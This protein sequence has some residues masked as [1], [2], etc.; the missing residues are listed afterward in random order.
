M[1]ER[2]EEGEKRKKTGIGEEEY[3]RPREEE[4]KETK[5][6][7][8]REERE[9]VPAAR[10]APAP[11]PPPPAPP[12]PPSPR[13]FLPPRASPIAG[14]TQDCGRGGGGGFTP[15]PVHT[16]P[17]IFDSWTLLLSGFRSVAAAA[18]P[19]R[20]PCR[21]AATSGSPVFSTDAPRE[22]STTSTVKEK[23]PVGSWT[24][25]AVTWVLDTDIEYGYNKQQ[26]QSQTQAVRGSLVRASSLQ[27]YLVPRDHGPLTKE[28]LPRDGSVRGWR[29]ARPVCVRLGVL[30]NKRLYTAT[31]HIGDGDGF[32]DRPQR[33]RQC[34]K[35]SPHSPPSLSRLPFPCP[36][37]AARRPRLLP[38]LLPPCSLLPLPPPLLT[39]HS[40]WL[41]CSNPTRSLSLLP[42]LSPVGGFQQRVATQVTAR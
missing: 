2:R 12:P 10:H 5:S 14:A 18:P 7:E 6:D 24:R 37:A 15:T 9:K 41:S 11:P 34:R 32:R 25:V 38:P 35:G 30:A 31:I 20:R 28:P 8:S 27:P 4:R 36:A 16:A 1:E 17:G 3:F 21:D 26:S 23:A 39:A 42:A 29:L 33:G 19:P 22:Q 13:P 40:A